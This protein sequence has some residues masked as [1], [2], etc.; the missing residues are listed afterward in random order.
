MFIY[1]FYGF[2]SLIVECFLLLLMHITCQVLDQLRRSMKKKVVA[3]MSSI[4]Y[5]G[6]NVFVHHVINATGKIPHK[7]P[8]HHPNELA[9]RMDM[10]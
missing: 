5:I 2:F 6:V 7:R 10:S 3:I 9:M 4:G 8:L 1:N